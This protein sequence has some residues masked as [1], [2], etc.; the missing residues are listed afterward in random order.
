MRDYESNYI[1]L[2]ELCRTYSR[3]HPNNSL[4]VQELID[5]GVELGK[6]ISM[7]EQAGDKRVYLWVDYEKEGELSESNVYYIYLNEDEYVLDIRQTIVNDT[8]ISF[9]DKLEKRVKES[10]KHYIVRE[11]NDNQVLLIDENF[12]V[13]S[14]TKEEL[15]SEGFEVIKQTYPSKPTTLR[16]NKMKSFLILNK[17]KK[18]PKEELD[19]VF[20]NFNL[21]RL[22]KEVFWNYLHEYNK[23]YLAFLSKLAQTLIYVHPKEIVPLL[24]ETGKGFLYLIIEQ[25]TLHRPPNIHYIFLQNLDSIREQY[26]PIKESTYV[27]YSSKLRKKTGQEFLYFQV[28]PRFFKS[29]NKMLYLLSSSNDKQEKWITKSALVQE[30]YEMCIKVFPSNPVLL[31]D[32][33]CRCQ[34][35]LVR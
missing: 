23:P 14:L 30:G 12:E 19:K 18:S 5:T 11:V 7:L 13:L 25:E 24:K 10:K 20:S 35:F 34:S 2:N 6:L 26:I 4:I 8:P 21:T 15:I 9:S 28:K 1:K 32:G 16:G 31:Y 17:Q 27:C 22:E 33:G 29:K 3:K